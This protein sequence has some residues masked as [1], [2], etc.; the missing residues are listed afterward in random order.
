MGNRS[1]RKGPWE[2]GGESLDSGIS[3][4]GEQVGAEATAQVLERGQS[5]LMRAHLK[6][7]Y[8]GEPWSAY[9]CKLIVDANLRRHG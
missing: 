7:E 4:I 9:G 2:G 1:R 3:G 8:G 5:G 6:V